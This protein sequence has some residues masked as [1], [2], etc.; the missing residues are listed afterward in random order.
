MYA[1][2]ES[3][4]KKIWE[5]NLAVYI[6]RSPN[7]RPVYARSAPAIFKNMT[8]FGIYGPAYEVALER[9]TG[10]L[11]WRTKLD[12]HPWAVITM[13]PTIENG[14]VCQGISSLE[15]A[16]SA[17]PDSPCCSHPGSMLALNAYTGAIIWQTYMI[18]LEIVGY[19]QYSG[20]SVWGSAPPVDAN[21]VY[22]ATGNLYAVPPDVEKCIR[23]CEANPQSCIGSPPCVPPNIHVDSVL[24]LEKT[25]GRIV[26]STR[27]QAT[28]AWNVQCLEGDEETCP[29]PDFDFA[30]AP[31]IF[32]KDGLVIGQKSGV[33]FGIN[34]L[35]GE[36]RW[37][38]AADPGSYLGGFLW[39]STLATDSCGN[40]TWIG[41]SANASNLPVVFPDGAS[42]N[43]S[44][45]VAINPLDGKIKWRTALPKFVHSFDAVSSTNKVA[46][47]PAFESGIMTA[48]SV[49]DGKTL[50]H[51]RTNAT[52]HGGPA[53]SGKRV[54][55]G[56]GYLSILGGTVGHNVYCFKA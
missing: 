37:S 8:I 41:A 10:N 7:G 20:C 11:V 48:Y 34:R 32:G 50:W 29:G 15:E 36:V 16:A 40:M 19:G 17:D 35:T 26:W 25:T 44:S 45:I 13:S 3:S 5:K 27:L 28:D 39:G 14:V 2:E 4:G 46:F 31:I 33:V 47:A 56:N 1:L 52:L 51:Y 24:A 30:Q 21:N 49:K 54:I 53:I 18:P 22:I 42:Y 55:F 38:N 23:D 12:D 6:E 43:V 9:S